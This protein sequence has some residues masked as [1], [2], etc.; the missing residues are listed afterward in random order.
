MGALRNIGVLARC[1]A[2]GTQDDIHAI[3]RAAVAWRDGVI[4][5]VGADDDLPAEFQND[6]QRYDAQ[7]KL[8]IPGLVDCHTHLAFGGWR[9]D[10]F[11]ARLRGATYLDIARAGGGVAS[12]VRQ[13]RA[14]S[15][16][17]IVNRCLAFLDRIVRLGV[18]TIECKSGYGLDVENELKLLEAYQTLQSLHP[19]RIVPTFL[20]A[21]VVPPE[22]RDRR[23]A[24][25]ALLTAEMIPQVAERRLAQFCDVFLEESAFT[26]P[27][28]EA[29]FA[30]G[31]RCGLRA[32]LHADQLSNGG[33]AAFAAQVNAVSADHLEW[34]DDDGIARLAQAGTVA[35]S[36]PIATLH[37]NQKPLRARAFLDAGVGVAV[38][39]DFNPGSAP[40]FHLPFAMT[41]ACTMQRMT[42]NEVLKGATAVAAQ[43]VEL[44]AVVGSVE[45][46]KAADLV[47]IDAP[48]VNHWLYHFQPNAALAVFIGGVPV[49]SE[50][51]S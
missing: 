6:A 24:Y 11:A 3:P 9:A 35:V 32:K 25:V 39:T 7:G 38:A 16:D 36:L 13:T 49:G 41:L 10:E 21:H 14:L 8:V 28:A 18:T 15:H 43:A 42:P 5:W 47:V 23:A 33:G 27:E 50:E 2:P 48:D 51:R 22:Y 40:S 29:I 12:T 46:G 34:T 30:A 17:A 31:A 44:D 20:G 1:L 19:V 37:L 4:A 26:R 45:I